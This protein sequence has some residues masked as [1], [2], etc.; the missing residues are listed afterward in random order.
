[1]DEHLSIE[2]TD[3]EG[4]YIIN[5]PTYKQSDDFVFEV[6]NRREMLR[7]GLNMTF[8]QE[9][10]SMSVNGVLRG[11]HVQKNF[12]QGKLVRVIKGTIYDVAVDTRINSSTY[13][14]WYGVE[15]SAENRKQFYIPEGFAHGFYVISDVAEVCF[16]VS[17]Y[18]H[19]NDEIG[20]PWNDPDLKIDWPIE[21]FGNPT[22]AEKDLHYDPFSLL[23]DKLIQRGE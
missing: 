11:L 18:W 21:K 15:L 2:K 20:I 13:G 12:P 6:Y 7:N 5:P 9:N 14:S 1:M 10:Q 16:K 17:N 4:L 23:K 19:P 8:V 22:I 3:I